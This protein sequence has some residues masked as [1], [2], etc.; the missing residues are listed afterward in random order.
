MPEHNLLGSFYYD[1]VNGQDL[2]NDAQQNIEGRL[3]GVAAIDGNIAVQDFLE[4]LS[5]GDQPLAVSDQLSSQRCA[6][7]LCG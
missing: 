7:L 1:P 3:D 2:I 5:I 4:H 6:S